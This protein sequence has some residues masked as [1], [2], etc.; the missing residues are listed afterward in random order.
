VKLS[1]PL[2]LVVFV[3]GA[4][5]SVPVPPPTAALPAN[6]TSALSQAHTEVGAGHLGRAWVLVANQAESSDEKTA[7]LAS[8]RSGLQDQLTAAQAKGASRHAEDLEATLALMSTGHWLPP[9]PVAETPA[10]G[11]PSRWLQGTATVF[12][13]R[14]LSVND[15]AARADVVLGSGFFISTDGLLLTNNHVIASMVDPKARVAARMWVAL[16]DSKGIRTPARVVGWDRNLDLALIKVETVP[17]Y[18]FTLG[19]GPDPLPGQKL[20]AI[21]SPGGLEQTITAG[22]ASAQKR[23]LLPV[24]DVIQIDVPVNPGN[25]GGPLLDESGRVVGVVFAGIADFRGVNFAIP[26]SLVQKDLPRLKLGGASVLPWLGLGL[27]EDEKGL[28]VIYVTPGSPGDGAGVRVGDRLTGVAGVP[29]TE[30]G[31][32]QTRLLDFGTDAVVPLDLTRDGKPLVLWSTLAR[33]PEFPLEDA[34][35]K[36]LV[37]KL[38]PLVLGAQVKDVDKGTDRAFE[39]TQVWPGTSADDLTLVPGDRLEVTQWSVNTKDHTLRTAWSLHRQADKGQSAMVKMD[40]DA[41]LHSFL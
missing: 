16:P 39:V 28:E 6:L 35:R 22:I 4:C 13:D 14:G 41:A 25:S 26:A 1:L 27:Q 20:Q 24:G 3:L 12:V 40:L 23:P 36:D 18:V 15:G 11:D 31:D 33:R 17:K 19:A 38:V 8:V 34:A 32:A 2:L 21:G 29:V 30:T 10:P 9:A 37:I 7:F 5:R